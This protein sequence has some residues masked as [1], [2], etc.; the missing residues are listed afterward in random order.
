M[1]SYSLNLK[2]LTCLA[3]FLIIA[4]L[5][6]KKTDTDKS[7]A[8]SATNNVAVTIDGVDI[9]Q[10]EI[11]RIVQSE[12]NRIAEKLAQLP[13]KYAEQV[14]TQI[15][16]QVLEQTIRR[17]LLDQKV[18]EANIVV[19]DEE[20]LNKIK[21][22]A[23]AQREPLTLEEFKNKMEQYGQSFDNVKEDV[24]KGLA[25]IKFMQTQWAGK[26]HVTEE[27]A[28]KY[29]DENPK[30]FEQPE[31]VRVSN[32]LIKPVLT[33]PNIEPN[34]DPNEDKAKAMAKAKEK[35]EELLKQLKDGADFA[36]LAKSHSNGPMAPR[37]GDIG[38][39]SKGDMVP[40]FEDVAFKLETGQI[41]DVVETEYGYH[42]IKATGH[43][44]A[45]K[46]PFDQVKDKIISQLTQAKE[47]ELANEY[48]ES[49]KARADIVY[50]PGKEPTTDAN[51]P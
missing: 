12:L 21:E 5:S 7:P 40:A 18:K 31:Q 28:K 4:G 47:S 25:R 17:H 42:I 51:N 49:L 48:I 43:K 44:E 11:D 2:I 34:I 24:R 27:D 19:T 38:F 23:A 14:K 46:L 13:P 45:G 20:V 1:R 3:I 36:E 32:I 26:I 22:I 15:R 37:G 39:F 29:Y 9:P 8:A 50:P 33:D 35:A 6:C 16:E 41:S 30:K 10:S